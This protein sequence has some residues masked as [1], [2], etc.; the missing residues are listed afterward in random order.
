MTGALI[1]TAVSKQNAATSKRELIGTY[2]SYL[3]SLK[4]FGLAFEGKEVKNDAGEFLGF[5]YS[6]HGHA[7]T[8][9]G[10]AVEAAAKGQARNKLLPQTADLR[11]GAKM[12]ENFLEVI[13]PSEGRSGSTILAERHALFASWAEFVKGLDK[14]DNVKRL[15]VL[16]VKQ[17]DALLT[18]G[19]KIKDATK[20]YLTEFGQLLAE[21]DSLTDWQTTYL[22]SI[23]DA[24]DGQ[25]TENDW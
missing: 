13:T 11:P 16:F 14:S 15:L 20:A 9:L 6:E 18:Q 1:T 25:T 7:A 8:W 23:I 4:E 10:N 21:K 3:P 24:C 2:T 5:D 22:S 19:E 17:P 12:P